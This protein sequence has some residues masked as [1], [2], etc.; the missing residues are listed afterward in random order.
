M[1]AG[2]SSNT[3]AHCR[4]SGA[5]DLMTATLT[6]PPIEQV[7]QNAIVRVRPGDLRT[8]QMALIG[9]GVGVLAI[10]CGIGM[11]ARG[12]VRARFFFSYLTG[13]RVVRDSGLLR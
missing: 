6:A 8:A 9:V 10:S 7:V 12:D 3:S 1:T 13:S 2:E 5:N 4:S 11:S